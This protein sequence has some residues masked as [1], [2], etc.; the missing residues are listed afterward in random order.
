MDGRQVYDGTVS[1]GTWLLVP[2]GSVPEAE[3]RSALEV[4][5]LYIPQTFMARLNASQSG[6]SLRTVAARCA[7]LIRD[8]HIAP[9][10]RSLRAGQGPLAEGQCATIAARLVHD[11]G[12]RV[13]QHVGREQLAPW[14]LTRIEELIIAEACAGLRAEDVS[15]ELGLSRSHLSRAYRKATGT[16]LR[17]AILQHRIDAARHMLVATPKA[18]TDIAL[19]TGFASASHM[20]TCFRTRLGQSPTALRKAVQR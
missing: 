13:A 8:P 4:L 14:Q 1:A 5:H 6:M 18:I 19:D 9:L 12:R 10:L 16:T 15:A 17:D 11:Y 7:Q 3:V 2:P 20:A